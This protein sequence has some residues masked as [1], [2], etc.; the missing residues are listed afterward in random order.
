M[1]AVPRS[2]IAGAKRRELTLA[3]VEYKSALSQIAGSEQDL[4]AAAGCT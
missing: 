4:R 1:A 3:Y 2:R